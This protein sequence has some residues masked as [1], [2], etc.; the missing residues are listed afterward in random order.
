M[1]KNLKRRK[2][3]QLLSEFLPIYIYT[4]WRGKNDVQKK[5]KNFFKKVLTY[6]NDCSIVYEVALCPRVWSGMKHPA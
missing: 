2:N 5:F 6:F 3:C 4:I 1:Q